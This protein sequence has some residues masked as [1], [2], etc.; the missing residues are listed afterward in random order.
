M[1]ENNAPLKLRLKSTD[2]NHF[3]VANNDASQQASP[4]PAATANAPTATQQVVDPISL[5]DTATGR[6]R[7]ISE[8]QD[9]QAAA[10]AMAMEAPNKTQTVRLKVVRQD[11]RSAGPQVP[12]QGGAKPGLT[13]SKPPAGPSET[14][15]VTPPA[16]SAER[17][18]LK[19]NLNKANEKPSEEQATVATPPPAPTA[20]PQK[21]AT[22]TLKKI[23]PEPNGSTPAAPSLK[24]PGNAPKAAAPAPSAT[25]KLAPPPMP[26]KTVATPPPKPAVAPTPTLAKPATPAPTPTLVKKP[27]APAAPTPAVSTALVVDSLPP[28]EA[29]AQTPLI[30]SISTLLAF[31]TGAAAVVF[32]VLTYLELLK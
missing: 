26:Q 11:N 19:L 25:V 28:Q 24:L 7:K 20:E 4:A 17:P 8:N 13:L 30:V 2:T 21:T 31:L 27:E 3:K 16:M 10:P 32:D 12:L 5:R 6:L 1:S 29:P 23:T 14:Q 9:T 22:V 18:A 15:A